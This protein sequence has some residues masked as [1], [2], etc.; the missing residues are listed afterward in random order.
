LEGFDQA[1][2]AVDPRSGQMGLGQDTG[3]IPVDEQGQ[4]EAAFAGPSTPSS[5]RGWPVSG[6]SS[7]LSAAT[8]NLTLVDVG[9]T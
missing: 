9:W 8:P 2:L 1:V 3:S 4:V 5:R 7:A 6:P